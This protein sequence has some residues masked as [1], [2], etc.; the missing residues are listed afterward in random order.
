MTR[1][2]LLKAVLL[3]TGT[4]IV[5][6]GAVMAPVL[7]SL[8]A[9]FADAPHAALKT[10]MTPSLPALFIVLG[11]PLAGR[12]T[13][14][15][16]RRP[17]LLGGLFLFALGGASGAVLND[18]DAILAGRAVLGLGVGA[19]MTA[20][21]TLIADY[22]HG[23][24]RTRLLGLQQA[25]S[26]GGA[27]VF[28]IA[29]GAMA[30]LSWRLPFTIYLIAAPLLVLAWFAADEP[31]RPVQS[32]ISAGAARGPLLPAVMIL[33]A[34]FVVMACFFITPVQIAYYLR[35]LAG[36]NAFQ[37]G[38]SIAW[39]SVCAMCGA[40]AY[41]RLKPHLGHV[42][43]IVLAAALMGTGYIVVGLASAYWTAMTGFSVMGLGFGLVLPNLAAWLTDIAPQA[44]R[45]RAVGGLTLALFLGQFVSPLASQPVIERASYG[46]AFLGA[47]GL[48]LTL[49]IVFAFAG[50]FLRRR[51]G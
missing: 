45:G 30:V 26:H 16:G 5:M 40:L 25:F 31:A 48:L 3:L 36:A 44:R 4:L 39:M 46:A 22:F 15:I 8:E 18:L 20:S 43:A 2:T 34:G 49:G 27:I 32:D 28:Q 35:D 33:A 17:V 50:P 37:S 38:L 12:L 6:A 10:R 1:A 23:A 13:D 14:T 47:A 11:A 41:P 51:E 7:P 21:I 19:V 24:E 42:R 29:A 9:A